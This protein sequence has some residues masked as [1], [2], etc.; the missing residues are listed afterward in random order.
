MHALCFGHQII[1]V[2]PPAG[3]AIR[4]LAGAEPREPAKRGVVAPSAK[5]AVLRNLAAPLQ[6]ERERAI[7]PGNRRVALAAT[8][9]ELGHEIRDEILRRG[10]GIQGTAIPVDGVIDLACATRRAAK[11]HEDADLGRVALE[12]LAVEAGGGVKAALSH[13]RVGTGAQDRDRRGVLSLDEAAGHRDHGEDPRGYHP[14]PFRHAMSPGVVDREWYG[15][16]RRRVSVPLA[17]LDPGR[18][19]RVDY[20]YIEH[21]YTGGGGT[22]VRKRQAGRPPEAYLPLPPATFHILLALADGELHGYAIMK[23]VAARSEGSVR[24]GP[25]TLYGSLK[26]LL[27]AGLVEECCERGEPERGDERRRYYRLTQL[28]LSVGRAGARRLRAMGRGAR[29]RKPDGGRAR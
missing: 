4:E 2:V 15:R 5:N 28:G 17:P 24:L 9:V 20:H 18:P 1:D 8:G 7:Q 10:A 27:K 14:A 29:G 11:T 19:S 23:G 12:N 6:A 21:R 13:E 25:G 26:R 16:L 3:D 22:I